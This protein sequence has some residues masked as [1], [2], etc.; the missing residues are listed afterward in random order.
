MA[1]M[2][3]SI[4]ERRSGDSGSLTGMVLLSVLGTFAS[5]SNTLSTSATSASA[6]SSLSAASL[7]LALATLLLLLA[8]ALVR[9]T[10]L[11]IIVRVSTPAT[12]IGEALSALAVV[13]AY[14]FS[15]FIFGDYGFLGFYEVEVIDIRALEHDGGDRI[16]FGR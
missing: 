1:G 15:A 13:L 9:T 2:R 6:I 16:P 3:D 14:D 10:A 8:V 7:V 4:G 5:L 11:L 12:N